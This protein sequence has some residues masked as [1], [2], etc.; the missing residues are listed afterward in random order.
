MTSPMPWRE[1]GRIGIPDHRAG[2]EEGIFRRGA[3]PGS[4]CVSSRAANIRAGVSRK[5]GRVPRSWRRERRPRP[6]SSACSAARRAQQYVTERSILR[7]LRI[8]RCSRRGSA[9]AGTAA[10]R[11]GPAARPDLRG[12]LE[13]H[14]LASWPFVHSRE[15]IV[16]WPSR[17]QR[18]SRERPVRR[19]G[20][21]NED[22]GHRGNALIRDRT[23]HG[24][25]YEIGMTGVL[26]A[27]RRRR[28]RHSEVPRPH[29]SSSA[30]GS[31][32]GTPRT[33]ARA[34]RDS[35]PGGR[36]SSS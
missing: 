23:P 36:I 33:A 16:R 29:C 7:V 35:T 30:A 26:R 6:R 12:G 11:P 20:I 31:S 24:P 32:S 18:S 9:G 17:R 22:G 13:Q 14:Q 21:D 10:A 27:G 5:F 28:R 4:T 34:V 3:T 15:P 2:R 19:V 1:E 25:W 8:A